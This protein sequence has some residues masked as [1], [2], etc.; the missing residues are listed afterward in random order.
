MVQQAYIPRWRQLSLS[1]KP[2][3]FPVLV[4]VDSLWSACIS[5][6]TFSSPSSMLVLLSLFRS[7]PRPVSF[8]LYYHPPAFWRD[9]TPPQMASSIHLE[10]KC[11]VTSFS[12][13]RHIPPK[14]WLKTSLC[15]IFSVLIWINQIA[16]KECITSHISLSWCHLCIIKQLLEGFKCGFV[17]KSIVNKR[18]MMKRLPLSMMSC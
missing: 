18:H 16:N 15:T 2:D 4:P 9:F 7:C 8:L 17:I 12:C 6:E 13:K 11:D 10:L 14:R 3:I 1:S 5:P